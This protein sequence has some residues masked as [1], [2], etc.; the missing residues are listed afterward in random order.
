MPPLPRGR[1]TGPE[2][3][4]RGRP[5]GAWARAGRGLGPHRKQSGPGPAR[6]RAQGLGGGQHLEGRDG[7]AGAERG[8]GS[9]V[10]VAGCVE[11]GAQ[12]AVSSG[13][14]ARTE[15]SGGRARARRSGSADAAAP[16]PAGAQCR[17]RGSRRRGPVARLAPPQ[18]K[19]SPS[20][21]CPGA[22][23]V[24]WWHKLGAQCLQLL[25]S[26]A[27]P[28]GRRRRLG[29][30]ESRQAGGKAQRLAEERAGARR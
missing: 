20:R 17:P 4:G 23:S 14:A 11:K 18:G 8:S 12:G 27:V 10:T 26:R 7:P 30:V 13:P 22:H 29:G 15:G 3:A 6:H 19:S 2:T 9:G 28:A 16:P 5:C 1:P 21:P 25:P 24:R